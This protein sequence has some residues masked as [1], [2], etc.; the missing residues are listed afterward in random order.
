MS[1]NIIADQILP[2]LPEKMGKSV[3]KTGL[4]NSLE[5]IRIRLH[6]PVQ[7]VAHQTETFLNEFPITKEIMQVTFQKLSRYSVYA[8]KEE[9]QEGFITLP[10]GHRAGLCGKMYYDAEGYRQIGDITSVNIRIAHEKPGC[11]RAFFHKLTDQDS[12]LDTLIVSPPG[13]GKTTYLR[14][15]VLHISEGYKDFP[16]KNISVVDERGEI[17]NDTMEGQGFHLGKRTDV[18]DRCPKAEGLLMMLR[19]MGPSVLAADE[20]GS[21]KDIEAL[22]IIRNSGCVLLMTAHGKSREELLRRPVLGEYLMSQPF[23]RYV[24]IKKQGGGERMVH[25]YDEQGLML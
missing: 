18:L 5:E 25:V 1:R 23:R 2:F 13:Y 9:I 10:G 11:C 22:R 16:G 15:L 20:I 17:G 21:D 19:T 24:V 4:W 6:Q 12:F 7:L 14:D 3:D 8:C